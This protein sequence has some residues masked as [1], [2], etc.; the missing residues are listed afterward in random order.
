M[1]LAIVQRLI[2]PVPHAST[3]LV[4]RADLAEHG[5]M[6]KGVLGCPVCQ[7]EWEVHN[8]IAHFGARAAHPANVVPD[9]ATLA[10]FLGLT[11]PQLVVTDGVPAQVV[12]SLVREFGAMVVALDADVAPTTATVLD[13]APIVPLA[14]GIASGAVLLRS[15]DAAFVASAVRSMAPEGR[16]VGIVALELPAGVREIARNN[17]LWVAVR[18]IPMVPVELLRRRT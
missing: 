17:E 12:E 2:C 4:V 8:G 1:D 10:A 6:Q 15:R 18:E 14:D 5:R 3:P 7:V 16:L 9:A 13:G 11:D